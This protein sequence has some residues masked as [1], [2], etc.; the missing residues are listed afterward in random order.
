M[1]KDSG[2]TFS[3]TPT[4]AG[5]WNRSTA[6]NTSKRMVYENS[7][8]NLVWQE[9]DPV[10]YIGS[11]PFNDQEINNLI[12][13]AEQTYTTFANIS[14]GTFLS[15]TGNDSTMRSYYD[16][17]RMECPNAYFNGSS[18]SFCIGTATDDVIAH[19]WTHGYTQETHGSDLR[20]AAGCSQ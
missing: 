2:N 19:E 8:S 11:D 9:G 4:M 5:F 18:T 3:S 15:Y 16:R 20:L 17:D 7:G 13:V 1:A 10:P 12:S 6:S 14:G